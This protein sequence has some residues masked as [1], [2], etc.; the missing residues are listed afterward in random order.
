MS[1]SRVVLLL[2]YG[3]HWANAYSLLTLDLEVDASN[4]EQVNNVDFP[5]ENGDGFYPCSNA[6]DAY[7]KVGMKAIFEIFC[8]SYFLQILFSVW[9]H[10]IFSAFPSCVVDLI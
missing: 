10:G 4:Y 6:T 2:G 8:Y 5:Y 1:C 7:A 9:R 3:I